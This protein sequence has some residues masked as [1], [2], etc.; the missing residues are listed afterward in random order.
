MHNALYLLYITKINS[1]SQTS[2]RDHQT[3]SAKSWL[4]C[5]I[6]RKLANM[7]G[8]NALMHAYTKRVT[9]ARVPRRI[10][11]VLV[12]GDIQEL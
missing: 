10:F 7:S 5:L 3:E 1:M 8:L 12:N 6:E 11:N 2:N 9:I 4:T